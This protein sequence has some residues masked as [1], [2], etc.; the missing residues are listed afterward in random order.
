MGKFRYLKVHG[1]GIGLDKR[2]TAGGACLVQ[3]DIADGPVLDFHALHVLTADIQNK[4]NARQE[5]FRAFVVRHGLDFTGIDFICRPNQ[6]FSVAG[7]H[8]PADICFFRERPVHFQQN[9]PNHCQRV[10]L[11][12]LVVFENQFLVPIDDRRL[13]SCRTGIDAQ[14]HRTLCRLNITSF[15]LG[16]R[17]AR[18]KLPVLLFIPEKR[19]QSL[20]SV[21]LRGI[22]MLNLVNQIG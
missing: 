21:H 6:A 12:I 7:N 4:R 2:A 16:F 15:H 10:S 11:V 9:I 20:C 22:R 8:R 3:H 17:M 14:E 13:G 18:L 19:F 1:L 5:L